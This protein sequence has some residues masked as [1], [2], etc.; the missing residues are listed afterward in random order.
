MLL[1]VKHLEILYGKNTPVVQDV[2][3]SLAAGEILAIVGESGS[4]K[5][6]VIRAIQN[7]LPVGGKVSHGEIFFEGKDILNLSDKEKRKLSG[8]EV[9][10]IFQDSGNM[11]NPIKT[12][13][14]QFYAYLKTHGFTDRQQA[15][16]KAVEMIDM[17]RLANPENILRS[18]VFELSGGMRQRVGIAMAMALN[19]LL[20]LADEPTSALDVTM[21]AQIIKEMMIVR[22]RLK[23]AIIIVTHNLGVASYMADKVLIMKDGRIVEYGDK[24]NVIMHPRND[25]TKILLDAVPK[26]GGRNIG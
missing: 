22:D 8:T 17:V 6:S 12:I 21:Q 5:T 26:L 15:H 16:G 10:M 18:Y 20:L 11:L 13:G 25:Y 7:C 24:K 2:S 9:S 1:E 23:A 19:P 3:F 14:E 4:G